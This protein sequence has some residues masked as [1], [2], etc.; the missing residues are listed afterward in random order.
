MGGGS[1]LLILLVMG[2]GSYLLFGNAKDA[3]STMNKDVYITEELNKLKVYFVEVCN[4]R[5][6]LVVR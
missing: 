5:E 1:Y 4:N 6:A 2:G 3:E